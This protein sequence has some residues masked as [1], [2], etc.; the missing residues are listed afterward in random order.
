MTH[1]CCFY[2]KV[3]IYIY[4]CVCVCWLSTHTRVRQFHVVCPKEL[5]Q[6]IPVEKRKFIVDIMCTELA[7]ILVIRVRETVC[8][9]IRQDC[10]TG[11]PQ[12]VLLHAW[13]P[14]I[15][16]YPCTHV[17]DGRWARSF[18]HPLTGLVFRSA[19]CL[20]TLLTRKTWSIYCFSNRWPDYWTDSFGFHSTSSALSDLTHIYIYIIIIIIMS[21]YQHGYFWP[22]LATP[23]YRPLPLAGL[24]GY[25]QYRHR[26]AVNMSKLD[27]LPLLGPVKG[28]HRSTS[29]MSSSLLLQQCPAC[30]VRLTLRVFVTDGRWPYRCCFVGCGLQDLF[31]F[32]HSILV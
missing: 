27:V 30:L 18:L 3:Y 5:Y 9:Q 20:A 25:I 31:S 23:P 11:I 22:S 16:M 7:P 12:L 28:V 19:G 21:R 4:M 10:K 15:S 29:F 14:T 24:P 26:A 8:E 6:E 17:L 2:E 32:A 13:I 1:G